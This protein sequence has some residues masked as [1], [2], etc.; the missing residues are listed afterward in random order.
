MSEGIFSGVYAHTKE[1]A[2]AR[3]STHTHAYRGR[4]KKSFELARGHTPDAS[5]SS[6]ET[7]VTQQIINGMSSDRAR[8][9]GMPREHTPGHRVRGTAWH[10]LPALSRRVSPRG[11]PP[12]AAFFSLSLRMRCVFWTRTDTTA[13]LNETRE[14]LLG[15]IWTPATLFADGQIA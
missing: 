8:G 13:G 6:R 2:H 7:T 4:E 10:T 12:G 15:R 5:A 3:A 14:S 9:M 1:Y 11:S